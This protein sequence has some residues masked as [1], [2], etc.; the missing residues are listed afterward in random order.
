[1]NFG[2]TYAGTS[3]LVVER[4]AATLSLA[5]N[6]ARERVSFDGV[7][8]DP[9][10][11]REAMSA[12]HEVVVG[13]LRFEKDRAAHTQWK[14]EQHALEEEQRRTL[15]AE[16]RA[17]EA[18]KGPPPPLPEG[19]ERDYEVLRR[20]YWR[21]YDRW[22]NELWREDPQLYRKLVPLDPVVTVAP[23][24]VFFEGFAKD[25]SSYG[26]VYA[27]R[28]GFQTRGDV[29]LGT[30]NV[31]YSLALYEHFQSIR[32][33]RETRLAIDPGSF[34]VAVQGEGTH[35]EEKIDL[36]SSWLRG[37]GQLT[38]AATLPSRTVDLSVE[39]MYSVLAFLQCNREKKGPRSI[40]FQLDPGRSVK[41][42]LDPWGVEIP[43]YGGPYRGP[44]AEEIKVWGRRRLKVLAR[45]LPF[46]DRISVSLL[47]SGLPTTWTVHMGSM[48]FVLALSG[49]TTN[50]WSSGAALD[51]LAG[52][53]RS[54]DRTLDALTR[55]LQSE[56]RATF[57]ELLA[58]VGASRESLLGSLHTL[59]KRGQVVFDPGSTAYRS[60]SILPMPLSS[61]MLGPEPEEVVQGR[62]LAAETEITAT[63]VL[64]K[65]T[66][67]VARAGGTSCEAMFDADGCFSRARC[68]CTF[69]R[70][71]KL[72]GGPCRHLIALRLSHSNPPTNPPA[73]PPA[74][75]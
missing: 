46:A 39:S 52:D 9:L 75:Q 21:A 43:V 59:A 36:P 61:A 34:G 2:L 45:T 74:K 66:L 48:R 44:K 4:D 60:R 64:T 14:Q 51:Q 67:V 31:D 12:L 62:R 3:E 40:R 30:T 16:F 7:I 38:A 71:M 23:D 27:D 26:C 28:S 32:T 69:F 10:R 42:V 8:E 33:Y 63:D 65:G 72:R 17:K 29:S 56:R 25:E 54:E 50:D 73:N 5:P 49:W 19:F 13:D 58:G 1:M 70:K 68:T 35:R 6:L 41:L 18:A 22:L 15:L 37:F 55:H 20:K 47:G 11:F 24:A 57:D 53:F